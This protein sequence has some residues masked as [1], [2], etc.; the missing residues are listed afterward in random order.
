M[1]LKRYGVIGKGQLGI[2]LEK[3]LLNETDKIARESMNSL[4]EDHS[5]KGQP[6]SHDGVK[7]N[8]REGSSELSRN[9]NGTFTGPSEMASNLIAYGRF[10]RSI[11][12]LDTRKRPFYSRSTMA[13]MVQN[14]IDKLEEDLTAIDR[15]GAI[16]HDK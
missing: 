1:D 12:E 8:I 2:E 3:S 15:K 11:K 4:A 16:K 6:L 10:E 13:K 14:A 9:L 5:V 7:V